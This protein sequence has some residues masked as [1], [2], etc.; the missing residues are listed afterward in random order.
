MR[1]SGVEENERKNTHEYLFWAIGCWLV[2]SVATDA[3]TWLLNTILFELRGSTC[4]SCVGIS[5][6]LVL[7][8]HNRN[9]NLV[10]RAVR[11]EA[12]SNAIDLG[13]QRMQYNQYRQPTMMS[14]W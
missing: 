2:R 14:I 6:R 11:A 12:T 5:N 4:P 1:A 9:I 10:Y 13:V 8:H 3:T 7:H